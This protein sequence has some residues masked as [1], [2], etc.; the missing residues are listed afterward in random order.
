MQLSVIILNYNVRYF[1]ELC[2]DSVFKAVQNIEAEVIVV[3]NNSPDDSCEMIRTKFPQVKLIPNP[4]NS[5]FPKGNNI[6]VAAASGQYICILNPDT[7]VAEDTFAKLIGFVQN[8]ENQG[9]IGVKMIDGTGNFL[10]ESKRGL[11]TPMIAVSKMLGLSAKKYYAGHLS[12]NETGNV[13]IL[14]GSCMFMERRVYLETGGFDERYFMY[15]EDID[16]SYNVL[17]SGRKNYYFPETSIIHFKGESTVKD[18]AYLDRFSS[19]MQLFYQKHFNGSALFGWFLKIGAVLFTKKKL[20]VKPALLNI[21]SFILFSRNEIFKSKLQTKFQKDVDCFDSYNKNVLL[22]QT[23]S[24]GAKIGVIF[25]AESMAYA[26]IIAVMQKY[27]GKG[28]VFRIRPY[29]ANFI[30]GSD[31]SNGRGEVIGLD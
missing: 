19:A 14:P 31:S 22:S 20:A 3:D 5:G 26:D 18:K 10:P 24:G 1:L 9:I 15:G 25:D 16:L 4:E 23:V 13:E 7:V 12:E 27:S 8:K 17:K 21:S 6:G 29:G 30:L 28:F 11:P 2:L